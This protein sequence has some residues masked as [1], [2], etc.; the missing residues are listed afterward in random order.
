[1]MNDD[2]SSDPTISHTPVEST[3]R[4]LLPSTTHAHEVTHARPTPASASAW[5][6]QGRKVT[7]AYGIRL[8]DECIFTWGKRLYEE[9]EPGELDNLP[10]A[11]VRSRVE[12]MT[13]ATIAY[14]PHKLYKQFP[15]LPGLRRNILLIP[16]RR[17]AL[18][19]LLVLK[20]NSSRE[21]VE[22]RIDPETLKS[23]KEFVGVGNQAAKWY[24]VTDRA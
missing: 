9:R 3:S 18:E 10:P 24:D 2:G 16:T 17:G 11:E 19:W 20:D 8:D 6:P 15:D 22:L 21:A 7:R 13:P 14:I 5:V 12:A 1:M 4:T 23:V